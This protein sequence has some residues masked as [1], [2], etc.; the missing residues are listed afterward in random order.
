MLRCLTKY[1]ENPQN[2]RRIW[3]FRNSGLFSGNIV[4]IAFSKHMLNIF[5]CASMRFVGENRNPDLS[6]FQFFKKFRDSL[7]RLDLVQT[8][9]CKNLCVQSKALLIMLEF[10]I[11]TVTQSPLHLTLVSISDKL[12]NLL[13]TDRRIAKM[14]EHQICRVI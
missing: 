6:L 11:S 13:L 4:K 14:L 12:A 9:L 7:I 10:F 1:I 2:T 8:M 3:L 5:N